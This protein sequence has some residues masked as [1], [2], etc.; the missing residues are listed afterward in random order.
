MFREVKR[1]KQRLNRDECIEILKKAKRGV[2]SVNGDDGYPYGVPLNHYYDEENGKIYFHGNL[3]GHKVEALRKNN[4][5]SFCVYD[6]GYREEGD[7]ALTFKS[8]IVFGTVREVED[9]ELILRI[10]RDLSYKF[11]S[12][13]EYIE[14]EI[15]SSGKRVL[16]HEL[17]IEHMTGKKIR[18]A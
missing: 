1:I 6:D 5:A 12:D 4:K 17:T 11:T 9:N 14:G 2:L 16:V 15:A 18:E 10:C 3:H 8:V 13:K 7:W